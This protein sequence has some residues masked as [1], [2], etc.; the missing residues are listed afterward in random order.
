MRPSGPWALNFSTQSRTICSVTPDPRRLGPRRTAVD[1]RE[2]Q[3]ASGLRGILR[4]S[5]CRTQTCRVEITPQRDGHGEPPPSA[6]LNQKTPASGNPTRS[7]DLG[8]LV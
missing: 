8:D 7:H 4:P 5:C 3:Q 2:R 6:I 1:R